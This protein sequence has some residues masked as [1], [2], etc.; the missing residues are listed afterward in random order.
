M[1][2]DTY[3]VPEDFP[4]PDIAA[5]VSGFQS[6]LLLVRYG[7]RFYLPGATPPERFARWSECEELALGFVEKCRHNETRKYA[8]LS[9]IKTLELFHA[10]L[11]QTGEGSEAELRWI[12]RR[13]AELLGWSIPE[14]SV[15]GQ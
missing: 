5:A 6:K 7:G 2:P 12:V 1:P 11:L 14:N 8:H 15:V 9:E 4:R 13:A 10:R 3:A